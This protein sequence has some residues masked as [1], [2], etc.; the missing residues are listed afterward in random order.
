MTTRVAY[1]PLPSYS[2]GIVAAKDIS[3]KVNARVGILWDRRRDL[4]QT[5]IE[6]TDDSANPIGTIPD[7]TNINQYVKTELN[8]SYK[9]KGN[10]AIGSGLNFYTLVYSKTK[11]RDFRIENQYKNYHYRTFNFDIPVFVSYS[12]YKFNTRL[13]FDKGII[14]R[15][16]DKSGNIREYENALTFQFTYFIIGKP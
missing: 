12:F 13:I 9:I 14:S 10:F 15:I 6:Y 1:L 7:R 3:P 4:D 8:L 5:N 16:K 2:F 11:I